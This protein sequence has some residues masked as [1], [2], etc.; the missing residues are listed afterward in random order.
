MGRAES[1]KIKDSNRMNRHLERRRQKKLVYTYIMDNA[2]SDYLLG[3]TV[4]RSST[5]EVV[6]YMSVHVQ[7]LGLDVSV[8]PEI[9]KGLVLSDSLGRG[10]FQK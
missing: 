1:K 3:E 4:S 10:V 7:G 9:E 6:S 8:V 2:Y 5:S